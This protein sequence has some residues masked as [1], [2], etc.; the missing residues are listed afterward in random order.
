MVLLILGLTS[1][2]LLFQLMKDLIVVWVMRDGV[3][4]FPLLLSTTSL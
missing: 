4:C 2:L 3:R 1:D